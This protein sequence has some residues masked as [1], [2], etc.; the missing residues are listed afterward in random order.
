MNRN[1]VYN[2]M[3]SRQYDEATMREFTMLSDEQFELW[4]RISGSD[5]LA[6]RGTWRKNR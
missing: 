3:V 2:I 4:F 5:F 6:G 1:D